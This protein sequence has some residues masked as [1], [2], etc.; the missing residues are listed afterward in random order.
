MCTMKKLQLLADNHLNGVVEMYQD[1]ARSWENNV[2]EERIWAEIGTDEF[3]SLV[4][5]VEAD[6]AE[7][8]RIAG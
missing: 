7:I 2:D 4:D 3:Q 8:F 5:R 6:A 1:E